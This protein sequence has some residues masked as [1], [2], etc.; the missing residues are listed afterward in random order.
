MLVHEQQQPED[1]VRKGLFYYS[2]KLGATMAVMKANTEHKEREARGADAIRLQV[3]VGHGWL[4]QCLLQYPAPSVAGPH[5]A[6]HPYKG[7]C[8]SRDQC[9]ERQSKQR[10]QPVQRLNCAM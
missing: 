10:G 6:L 1:R 9:R 4:L 7:G 2:T 8:G 3:S 5:C